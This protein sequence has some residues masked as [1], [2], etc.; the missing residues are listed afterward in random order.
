MADPYPLRP[1]TED[2]YDAFHLVE[3][4]AFNVGS[5]TKAERALSLSRFEFD[6]SI[7]AFDGSQPVGT[8]GAY[9]L[10][11]SVPG[12]VLSAAGVS[13]VSVLPSHRRRGILRTMMRRQ[14][15]DVA[16]RGEPI[17]TLWASEAPLYGR[18]GYGAAT[19]QAS[20]AFKRAEGALAHAAPADQDLRLRL[21][22]PGDVRKDL[23]KVFDA[24][25]PGQPGFYARNDTWWDYVTNDPEELRQGRGPLRC[26][27][28]EDPGGARGYALYRA[29][30]RWVEQEFLPDGKLTIKELVAADPAAGAALWQHL[31]DRDLVTE[32]EARL[33]PIDDPLLFQIADPR[34]A[35]PQVIDGLWVRLVDLPAALRAR[36]Y[37]CPVTAVIEVRDELLPANSGRWRLDV[38]SGETDTVSCEPTTAPADISLDVRALGAAYLGAIRLGSFGTAGLI[39]EHRPGTLRRLSAAMTWTPTAWC[40][41]I[42]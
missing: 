3:Q 31:L 11:L 17:A 6:R 13:Y 38:H 5:Q 7:A 15:T 32:V 34:R 33:R 26:V 37:S 20:F 14:L 39:T 27:I 16:E 9:S 23:G 36:A 19:L 12:T 8:A 4:L 29:L 10:Q 1:I 2:E 42:F 41:V 24:V 22:D 25:Q 18:Y 40:P 21:A 30:D 28:A 35:R